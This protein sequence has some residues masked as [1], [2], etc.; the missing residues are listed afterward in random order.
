[1]TTREADMATED[2]NRTSHYW[3]GHVS[4]QQE[5]GLSRAEY[6]RRQNLSYHALTY[7]RKKLARSS[8]ASAALVPVPIEKL[9]SPSSTGYGAGIK[10]ILNNGGAIEVAEQF[11]PETLLKVLSVLERR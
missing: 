8:P 9:L 1:M 6:C 2:K 3:Q 7:W 11:S 10:I 5:S 4:A